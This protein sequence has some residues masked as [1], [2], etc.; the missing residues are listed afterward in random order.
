M[1]FDD[2]LLERQ[3]KCEAYYTRGRHRNVDCFYLAQNYFR[4][5]RQTIYIDKIKEQHNIEHMVNNMD[6]FY[7]KKDKGQIIPGIPPILYPRLRT[8]FRENK[9]DPLKIT[10]GIYDINNDEIDYSS[11]F[12]QKCKVVVDLIVDSIFIG[13]KPSIQMK[14]DTII[15]VQKFENIRRLYIENIQEDNENEEIAKID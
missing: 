10:T 2:L 15:V 12:N 3:N 1:V 9:N 4:L 13:V 7:R 6:I 5:P 8:A 11:I 14:I